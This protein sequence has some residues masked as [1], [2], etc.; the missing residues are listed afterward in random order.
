VLEGKEH[1]ARQREIVAHLER[2]SATSTTLQRAHELLQE[3][4]R[5]QS[6]TLRTGTGSLGSCLETSTDHG[7]GKRRSPVPT[8]LL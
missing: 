4:E 1:I 3:V 8:L 7:G 2:T 6:D 5:A